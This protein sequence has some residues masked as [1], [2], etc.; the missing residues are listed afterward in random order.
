MCL[1]PASTF[2]CH[3]LWL[4]PWRVV[5]F[6]PDLNTLA[7][8]PSF[9]VLAILF[10]SQRTYASWS[11]EAHLFASTLAFHPCGLSAVWLGWWLICPLEGLV[12]LSC[13]SGVSLH[14]SLLTGDERISSPGASLPSVHPLSGS[15][16]LTSS[17]SDAFSPFLLAH[18]ILFFSTFEEYLK[19]ST[20][21]HNKGTWAHNW[22]TS[23]L[24]HSGPKHLQAEALSAL[25]EMEVAPNLKQFLESQGFS[26]VFALFCCLRGPLLL[27]L[28]SESLW[29]QGIPKSF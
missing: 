14:L 3:L 13:H 15:S 4:S 12:V 2:L 24:I 5:R 29:N 16:V 19:L 22:S 11:Q 9:I 7:D 17:C 21:N 28:T 6:H 1:R 8:L 10:F 20:Q 18:F 27:F 23:A 26:F 25:E